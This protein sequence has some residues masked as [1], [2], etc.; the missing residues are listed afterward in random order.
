MRKEEKLVLACFV[1]PINNK[2]ANFEENMDYLLTT[3]EN[4]WDIEDV[5]Y[6]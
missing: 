3:P 5:F 2:H 4:D 1:Y 6:K